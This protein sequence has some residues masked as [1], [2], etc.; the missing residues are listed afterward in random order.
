MLATLAQTLDLL[1]R[2]TALTAVGVALVIAGT[3]WA[4]RN[5]R[6]DSSRGWAR[7][8]RRL[9]D[10]VL[11]PIEHRVMRAGGNPRDATF[12]LLGITIAA[13]L[14]LV[15]LERWLAGL[16][17]SLT[18]FTHYGPS[19]WIRLLLNAAIGVLMLA[20]VIRVVGSW[21]GV[22]EYHRWMRPI[23][24]ATEWLIRPIRRLLPP[25]GPIDFSP[26]VAY[27]LLWLLRGLVAGR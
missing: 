2:A 6:I 24:R 1:V 20:I 10:P 4:I 13:G 22:S 3:Q 16:L 27:L 18:G 19:A 11:R 7:G 21:V 8:M 5:R 12:W 17:L 26:V 15:G 25:T 14:V 23:Y 9:S